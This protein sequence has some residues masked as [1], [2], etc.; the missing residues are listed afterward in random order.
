VTTLVTR[1]PAVPLR[2]A[3]GAFGLPGSTDFHGRL[4]RAAA[5]LSVI[6]QF[7]QTAYI[8][9]G[10]D[11]FGMPGWLVADF[12]ERAIDIVRRRGKCAVGCQEV[13]RVAVDEDDIVPHWMAFDDTGEPHSSTL[14]PR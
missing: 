7:P 10:D 5:H 6:A 2:R 12:V 1:L 4:R 13:A 14:S 3:V 9:F 11:A 8:H